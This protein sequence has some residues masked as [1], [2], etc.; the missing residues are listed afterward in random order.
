MKRQSIKYGNK[1]VKRFVYICLASGTH[2]G[3][4]Q[5]VLTDFYKGEGLI[6]HTSVLHAR[7]RYPGQ[8][9]EISDGQRN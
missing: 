7:E 3:W 2:I 5:I 4:V 1:I 9:G 6:K 8:Y